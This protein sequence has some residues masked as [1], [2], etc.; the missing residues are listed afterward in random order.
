MNISIDKRYCNRFIHLGRPICSVNHSSAS[1]CLQSR[2][3][4]GCAHARVDVT[5]ASRLSPNLRPESDHCYTVL[6]LFRQ[7]IAS[8]II[9]ITSSPTCCASTNSIAI[10][11]ITMKDPFCQSI[12]HQQQSAIFS[13]YVIAQWL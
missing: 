10:D 11:L 7:P 8:P 6:L 9:V 3:H 1:L 4:L 5:L 12:G 2:P 13:C